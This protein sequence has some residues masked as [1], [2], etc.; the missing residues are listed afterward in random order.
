MG[1]F[2]DIGDITYITVPPKEEYITPIKR[3]T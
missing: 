2:E 1:C 3:G